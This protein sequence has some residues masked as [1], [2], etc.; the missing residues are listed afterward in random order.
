VDLSLSDEQRSLVEALGGLFTRHAGAAR[1]RELADALDRPL[2]TLLH[3]QGFLDIATESRLLDAVLLVEQAEAAYARAPI[4]ARAVVAPLVLK[5]EPELAVALVSSPD[6]LVRHAGQCD[7]Y[8]VL[9]GDEAHVA[10]A[11]QVT[12][13][14]VPSRWGYPLGRV[15]VQ[16]RVSLGA[17]SGRR[18]RSAW[19]I[20]LAAE[21]GAQMRRAVALTAAYVTERHQFGRPIGGYQA[22]AHQLAAAEVFA[23]GTTWLT[24]RAA[25][26]PDD[27]ALAAA[28]A[29]YAC[30]GARVVVEATHQVT[31]AIGIAKEY[32]LVLSTMRLA[33]LESELGGGA[34]HAQDVSQQRWLARSS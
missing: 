2:L 34:A 12:V 8:L 13:E 31:G 1:A 29:A 19:Q 20:A 27:G 16:D 14:P 26:D 23:Q 4:A 28:A 10:T 3:D 15:A 32:D 17:G 25:W 30:E 5:D 18:L 22:V 9:D 33:F 21:M 11:A 7:T 24:R 6:A